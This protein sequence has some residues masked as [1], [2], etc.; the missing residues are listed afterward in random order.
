MPGCRFAIS[1]EIK[2]GRAFFI[3]YPE[4]AVD[5]DSFFNLNG[6]GGGIGRGK[7]GVAKRVKRGVNKW[8]DDLQ[9]LWSIQKR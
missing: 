6:M 3:A 8:E 5:F 7:P 2:D 1:M 4:P 9:N